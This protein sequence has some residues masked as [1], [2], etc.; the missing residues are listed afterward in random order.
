M[1]KSVLETT[2]K[3]CFQTGNSMGFRSGIH[4]AAKNHSRTFATFRTEYI[5]ISP[6]VLQELEKTKMH[7]ID[8]LKLV[9][10]ALDMT[11]E[12]LDEYNE[13]DRLVARENLAKDMPKEICGFFTEYLRER[14][15]IL[16]ENIPNDTLESNEI[17]KLKEKVFEKIPGSVS[18]VLNDM[19]HN[20][21][22]NSSKDFS[23]IKY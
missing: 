20:I 4:Q 12:M 22:K 17:H 19:L 15:N 8:S 18:Y 11:N 3:K 1:L 21:R 5:F 14:V 2:T 23:K 9:K 7:T 10:T 13:D 6:T 16:C